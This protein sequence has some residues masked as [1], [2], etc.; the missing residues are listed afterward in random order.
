MTTQSKYIMVV[1]NTEYTAL[2][3]T[4]FEQVNIK[5]LVHVLEIKTFL[6]KN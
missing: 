5:K 6:Q 1:L 2:Y 3:Y 4:M